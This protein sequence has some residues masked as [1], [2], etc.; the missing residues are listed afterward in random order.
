MKAGRE[1]GW[2]DLH[3]LRKAFRLSL[4]VQLPT[5]RALPTF[6]RRSTRMLQPH[7]QAFVSPGA[8]SGGLA[9]PAGDWDIPDTFLPLARSAG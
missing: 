8:Q 1:A 2:L 7:L 4:R 5:L 3:R 6:P 9:L